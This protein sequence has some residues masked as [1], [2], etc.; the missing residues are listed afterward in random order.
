MVT[1]V[2]TLIKPL[3]INSEGEMIIII[4]IIIIITRCYQVHPKL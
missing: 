2:V 1:S 4:I 3:V